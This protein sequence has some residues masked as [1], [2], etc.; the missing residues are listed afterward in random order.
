[1]IFKMHAGTFTQHV[2]KTHKTIK[3]NQENK[4]TEI[5]HDNV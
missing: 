4:K 3:R 1:M 5:K 2:Y